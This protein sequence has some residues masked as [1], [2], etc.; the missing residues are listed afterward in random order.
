M[1]Y[2]SEQCCEAPLCRQNICCKWVS[3]VDN[4]KFP[5]VSWFSSLCSIAKSVHILPF[6][7]CCS[8]F[9]HWPQPTGKAQSAVWCEQNPNP[10]YM[11]NPNSNPILP[12]LWSVIR[13]LPDVVITASTD[14]FGKLWDPMKTADV[15]LCFLLRRN[16]VKFESRLDRCANM[17]LF[18]LDANL[19]LKLDLGIEVKAC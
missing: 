12:V 4:Y 9:N 18:P 15:S 7:S 17:E 11:P 8:T 6:I 10:N 19:H 5:L 16:G 3:Y 2:L 1:E 13:I 14:W